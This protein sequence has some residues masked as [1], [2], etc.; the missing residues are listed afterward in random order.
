[1]LSLTSGTRVRFRAPKNDAGHLGTIVGLSPSQALP[2]GFILICADSPSTEFRNGDEYTGQNHGVIVSRRRISR[3]P[4]QTGVKAFA[5]VPQHIGI[6]VETGFDWDDARFR[7]G[8]CG[9]LLHIDGEQATISWH[10]VRN[11]NFYISDPAPGPRRTGRPGKRYEN[12]YSVPTE[13][14][15]W[16]RW[17]SNHEVCKVWPGG[18]QQPS[19]KFEVG[20]YVVYIA[21]NATR[22]TG[23]RH[24]AVAQGTILRIQDYSGDR[25]RSYVAALVGGG[26]ENGQGLQ[27]N[28]PATALAPLG[29]PYLLAGNQVEI[30]ASIEFKKRDLR[31]RRGVVI[32]P[33]DADGDVGVQFQENIGAGSL[34]GVGKNLHCLYVPTSTVRKI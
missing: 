5:G 16:C 14:L 30:V 17:D 25:G 10:D 15:R 6:V 32:L 24:F 19:A 22:A 18:V 12:C 21:T 11:R 29:F 7:G 27:V 31:G 8:T 26:A 20:D 33:T 1:M 9:R 4:D 34:D 2:K 23:S 28:L 13:F 3:L